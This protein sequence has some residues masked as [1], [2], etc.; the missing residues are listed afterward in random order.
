VLYVCVASA[1]EPRMCVCGRPSSC[2]Q[3]CVVCV[4]WPAIEPRSDLARE[5]EHER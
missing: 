3:R 4:L 5:R 1:V 2:E